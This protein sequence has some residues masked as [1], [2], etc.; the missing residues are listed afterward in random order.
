MYLDEFLPFTFP[1]VMYYFG[2]AHSFLAAWKFFAY[3]IGFGGFAFGIIGFNA[4]NWLMV[5]LT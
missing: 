2:G 3:I 4:G 1:I 5:K